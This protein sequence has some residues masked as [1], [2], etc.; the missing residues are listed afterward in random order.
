MTIKQRFFTSVFATSLL[1]SACGGSSSVN[2]EFNVYFFTANVNANLVDSIFN[3]PA[4][5]LIERPEDPVRSGFEFVGWYNDVALTNAWDFSV[6]LMPEASMVLYAKWDVGIS[7]ITYNLNG[8]TM[9]TENYPVQF[10][11]GD[12]VILPQASRVGYTFKGWFAYDQNFDLYPNSEGTRPGD[13]P[14]VTITASSYEDI[15]IYAHWVVI[16][17]IVSFRSNHPGGT[18]VVPNPGTIRVSYGTIISFGTNFPEDFGTVAGFLFL[19]WNSK[20]NGTG[21]WYINDTV[22]IKTSSITIYGQWQPVA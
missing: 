8:G 9:T 5:T 11:P 21:D 3:Q 15:V 13:K 1:L 7:T 10:T 17:A 14:I 4:G 18:A 6:D 16:Q 20:S 22:F 19:G 2:Q 12:N